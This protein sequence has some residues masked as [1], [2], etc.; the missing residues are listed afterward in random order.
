MFFRYHG[1]VAVYSTK[2]ALSQ[3]KGGS[4]ARGVAAQAVL[5]RT[6][7]YTAYRRDSLMYLGLAFDG[8]SKISV[9][10]KRLNA[11]DAPP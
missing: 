3:L 6:S 9:S 7:P 10:G 2:F 1:G 8:P 11:R 5:W 4:V